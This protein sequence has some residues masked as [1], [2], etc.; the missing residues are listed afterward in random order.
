MT[1]Q[2]SP[3]KNYVFTINNYTP[4]DVEKM[5]TFFTQYC[6][7]LCFGLECGESGTPHIQG[8]LQ[9]KDKA[10]LTFLKKALHP[11]AHFEV[12]RGT[13]AEA[14]DYCKKEHR[15]T[16]FGIMST[17]GARRDLSEL[18]DAVVAGTR[19]LELA[20]TDPEHYVRYHKGLHALANSLVQPRNFKTKVFWLF[21]PTGSGKS[22]WVEQ[23]SPNAYWKDPCS[24]WW[25][26]YDGED[27]V[28]D[29]YRR[30]FCTFAALLRLL[31][32]YPLTVEVKGGSTQFRSKR[33]YITTPKHPKE[34]WEGRTEEDL[35]QLLRRIDEILVFP[36]NEPYDFV[37]YNQD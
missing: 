26:G 20:K 14:S 27:V 11:T 6:G 4:A 7:Y 23:T 8:Y 22:K 21:G 17:I 5:G 16:E 25:C 9:L 19:P 12:A 36:T 10:R 35:A 1:K 13:P 3:A 31:D 2:Q 15:F 18:C 32:R 34:T 24:K 37:N 33:L 28:I 29:D 30:D